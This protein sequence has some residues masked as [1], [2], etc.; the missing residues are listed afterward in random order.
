MRC[1]CA[2]DVR[3]PIEDGGGLEPL[4]VVERR[5]PANDFT[6]RHIV[7]NAGLRG[8]DD[9]VAELAVSGNADLPGE[10]GVSADLRRA[11]E[12]HLGT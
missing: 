3:Q 5:R 8:H 11:G 10:D 12:A 1:N 7:R 4:A 6:W 9:A 2:D